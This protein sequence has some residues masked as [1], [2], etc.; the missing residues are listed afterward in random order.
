MFAVPAAVVCMEESLLLSDSDSDADA[1]PRRLA[2]IVSHCV[3][4]NS[5]NNIDHTMQLLIPY[6][7]RRSQA[8]WTGSI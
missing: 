6:V 2:M 8:F 1:G 7:V 5:V 4:I 3:S